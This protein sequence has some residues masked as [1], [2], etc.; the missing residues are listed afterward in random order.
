MAAPIIIIGAGTAG[1]V[2]ASRL[3]A[4]PARKIVLLEAGS[5]PTD[6]RIMDPAAWPLLEG[7]AIDWGYS[8]I[9]Q[10]HTAGRVHTCPRG[11]VVGGSTAINAMGHMRGHPADFDAWAAAG[12]TGWDAA[13][14]APYFARSET[15][16]FAG[17]PGYGADGPLSLVQP[18]APHPLTNAHRAACQN[19]GLAPIRDHNGGGMAGPTL[20]TLTLVGGRRQTIADAYLSPSV[21]ARTNLI[22]RTDVLV[23]SVVL[24][25]QFCVTGVAVIADG[26]RE[27]VEASAVI[28]AAGAIGSPSILMRSGV[29]PA[30]ELQALGIKVVRDLPG[31][32][33][34]LQDHLLSGGNV[35]RARQP[36]PPTTTQHSES[37]CYLHAKG[38]DPAEA[39]H[40]VVGIITVPVV[41]DA[42]RDRSGLPGI[43]EGYTLVY[44]ITHPQSRGTVRLSSTAPDAPPLIDPAYLS[45]EADRLWFREALS[46]AR[47]IGHAEAY[48]S[49]RAE[50]VLPAPADLQDQAA[51]DAFIAR[52]AI[53]HH[54]PVGTCRMGT[55]ID[56]VV[57]PGLAV[58][59]TRHLFVVDGAVM[60]SLTTGPVNAAIVAIAER[61]SDVLDLR[62]EA[63]A[64]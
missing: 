41:S 51:T 7:S 25:D 18:A 16:P 50:E 4:D 2:L 27:V 9:P 63:A 54:H 57:D 47:R 44:G 35:Y 40:L 38:Q 12:A 39:P 45:A 26:Q 58:R 20:N 37:L 23:D 52:A 31:V 48:D 46:A 15:S 28:L 36:V 19:L 6:P 14:L 60:P 62:V 13:A 8:T 30:A 17:E 42:L 3:S 59:G 1:A 64:S 61:A 24:N 55:D 56:A 5:E 10:R 53:T 43:G 21:R 34:N 32:G 11:R 22:L 49:W 33:K 29:G